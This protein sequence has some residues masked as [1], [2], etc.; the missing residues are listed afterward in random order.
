[1]SEKYEFTQKGGFTIKSLTA[2]GRECQFYERLAA[3]QRLRAIGWDDSRRIIDVEIE[4]VDMSD[5]PDFCDA[6]VSY[7]RW[8]DTGVE[9]TDEELDLFND[10]HWGYASEHIHLGGLGDVLGEA[11]D[12]AMAIYKEL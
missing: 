10:R 11:I 5:W 3:R 1:M 7:A 2:F 4:G 9:L 12:D 6:Y 8:A